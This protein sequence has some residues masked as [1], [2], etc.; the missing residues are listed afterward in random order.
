LTRTNLQ[1]GFA[2]AL[3]QDLGPPAGPALE[4]LS[5][6][7]RHLSVIPDDYD[8]SDW[9]RTARAIRRLS[10]T[11]DEVISILV[12]R[13]SWT[14]ERERGTPAAILLRVYPASPEAI[15]TLTQIARDP[16]GLRLFAIE[17]LRK[18]GPAAKAAIPALK[19]VAQGLD[20]DVNR[21]AVR[22]LKAIERE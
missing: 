3:L 10:P 5:Q 1:P 14:K 22:A 2:L 6:H 8:P 9:E 13:L 15:A 19:A 21:A 17:E 12:D 11:N 18:A 4:F 7:L 20:P 16:A